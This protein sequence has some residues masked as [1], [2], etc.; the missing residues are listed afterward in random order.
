MEAHYRTQAGAPLVI[1][2][3]PQDQRMTTDFALEIPYGL[4]FLATHDP[5]AK[6]VGLEEFPRDQWPDV[7][8]VHWS[9]DI[10]VGSGMLMLGLTLCAGVLWLKYRL[11]PDSRWLLRGL[12]AAGPLGFLAIE[13]GWVVTE[14]G[15][16]PWII[17]GVMRTREAV[18][19]MPGLAVPFV[20]FAAEDLQ[21]HADTRNGKGEAQRGSMK[22]VAPVTQQK[23]S[24]NCRHHKARGHKCRQSHM[25]DF[26]KS[27]GVQHRS[28]RVDVGKLSIDG[29]ESGG[30]VH[31]RTRR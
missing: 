12:V 4:S 2:G 13:T 27:S 5:N 31:P 15:R 23:K 30:C 18:T 1:G 19:P 7:R 22:R 29:F 24:M 28:D 21:W 14:A 8:V 11:L 17:Y 25:H 9:F 16:Q 10:M 26:G 20:I 3:I 6:V